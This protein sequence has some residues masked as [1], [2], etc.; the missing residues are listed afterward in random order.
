MIILDNK[1]NISLSCNSLI[2][3]S[4]KAAL[5]AFFY[6][7]VICRDFR[8]REDRTLPVSETS[9]GFFI[10][11]STGEKMRTTIYDK[12]FDLSGEFELLKA[13]YEEFEILLSSNEETYCNKGAV[14][15]MLNMKNE[16]LMKQLYELTF[17]MKGEG[18]EIQ[19]HHD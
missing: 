13:A 11:L 4:V 14:L 5:N 2:T 19:I 6:W 1:T 3:G 17:Q 8:F 15:I 18:D 7:K 10:C 12:L 16:Q 9:L